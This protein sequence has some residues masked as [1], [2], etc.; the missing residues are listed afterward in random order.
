MPTAYSCTSNAY[1]NIRIGTYYN[2]CNVST[3][4][5]LII[6]LKQILKTH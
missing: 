4:M 5:D 6:S 3:F 1:S 2:N